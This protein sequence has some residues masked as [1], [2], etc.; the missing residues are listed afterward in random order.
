MTS[1]LDHIQG[2]T[3]TDP[4]ITTVISTFAGLAG[5]AVLVAIVSF[6]SVAFQAECLITEV[7]PKKN[8]DN[9]GVFVTLKV[10]ASDSPENVKVGKTYVIA[11]F[12]QH[13]SIPDFVIGKMAQ[14]RREFA[15]AL[16]QVTCTEE[17]KA[18]PTLLKL[19]KETESL[20]IPMVIRNKFIRTTRTGKAVH[21][22]QFA[23]D[24]GASK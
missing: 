2:M 21:E 14:S 16:D 24:T 9:R 11:F 19:S 18:A 13:K 1:C 20:N 15:A 23:L 8:Y 7:R 6:G 10:T 4:V 3:R 17:Y 12:D 5:V 22:L